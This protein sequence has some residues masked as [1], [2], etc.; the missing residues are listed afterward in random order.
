MKHLRRSPRRRGRRVAAGL[1]VS[2]LVTGLISM[3]N[4]AGAAE[5][6][7]NGEVYGGGISAGAPWVLDFPN[8]QAPFVDVAVH[9]LSGA[10]HTTL[11]VTASGD[12]VT[13]GNY[14]GIVS[15]I[16]PSL[17]NEHVIAIEAFRGRAAAVTQSGKIVTWSNA[18]TPPAAY[19][20]PT[21]PTGVVD[22][23]L[24]DDF[25]VAL[26]DD[27]T[28]DS[29]GNAG[30]VSGTPDLDNVV[31]ID[32]TRSG[33][34][35]LTADGTVHAWGAGSSPLGNGLDEVNTSKIIDIAMAN[36]TGWALTDEGEVLNFGDVDGPEA[37][38]VFPADRAEGR[39]IALQSNSGSFN[40]GG[41]A[42]T[43]NGEFVIWG[44]F[45]EANELAATPAPVELDEQQ[46]VA[47]EGAPTNHT[48]V[49]FG[50]KDDEPEPGVVSPPAVDGFPVVGSDVTGTPATFN[51]EPTSATS[52]WYRAPSPETP[53][54]DW[55]L[56][57]ET[58]PLELTSELE[59]QYVAYRTTVEGPEGATFTADSTPI[60]PIE[61]A[62]PGVVDEAKIEGIP[63]RNTQLIGIA[64]TFNFTPESVVSEWYRADS[65]DADPETWTLVS[66]A[67]PLTVATANEGKFLFFR[68]T[69]TDEGG[70]T[71]V[72][73]SAPMGPIVRFTGAPSSIQGD[74][75]VGST[76]TG[77]PGEFTYPPESMT[78]FWLVGGTQRI[79]V[80]EGGSLDLAMTEDYVGKTVQFFAQ[81]RV[82][83]LLATSFSPAI[84]PVTLPPLSAVEVPQVEGIP[85]RNTQLIGIAAVFNRPPE[86]VVSEW[87]RADSADADPETWTLVSSA[88]PL[89]VAT[90][91][92]GKFLFFRTTATDEGGQTFVS[93]SAPMGP[94]VRFTGAPSSIQGDP[95][96]GSTITGVP[97]EFTYPP[98]SMT[99]FWLVG[100]TQRIDVPEGGSLD[101]AMTEDYVGKTVQFF[102][103]GRVAGLLAT[104][105]SPAIGPVT[106][107][108]LELSGQPTVTG[109]PF[110]GET[111]TATPVEVDEGLESGLQWFAGSGDTFT[112]IEG[113]TGETFE[114]TEAQRDQQVKVVQTATRTADE[115]TDSAESVPTAA[116]TD[117]PVDLV[118]EAGA[119][120]SGTPIEG[121]TLTGTPAVYSTTEDVTVTNYWVIG[122]EEVEADGTTLVLTDEH[123]GLNIQFKSVATRGEEAVPSVSS[124]VGPVLVVLEA[125]SPPT[126]TGTPE[127]GQ[128][129]NGAPATFSDTDGVTVTNQWFADGDPIDGATTT[130]LVLT[131]DHLGAEITFVSTATRGDETPVVSESDPTAPVEEEDTTTPPGGEVVIDLDGATAPGAT[132]SVQVGT[133]LAGQQVQVYLSNLDR[134]LGPVTVAEDGTIQVLVPGDIPLGTH[135]LA[136]YAEGQLVG[137]DDFEVTL[138]RPEDPAFQDLINVS[139]DPV[140]AG[141]EV[142]IQVGAD[143][144]GQQVRVVLFSTPRDLG[145]AT[146][147]ADGTVKVTIPADMAAGV[148]RVAVYDATG[149]LIGW[150]DVTVAGDGASG[151]GSGAGNLPSTGAGDVGPMIPLGLT[152][153]LAGLGLLAYRAR[154]RHQLS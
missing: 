1:V 135:R 107:P 47:F 117:A 129:L 5:T 124:A 90:A 123:V 101:L 78:Y 95:L 147:A 154:G 22:V 6:V 125:T 25:G 97:G 79:D 98:E 44:D 75:L 20:N 74:P 108:P 31:Q 10:N 42:L 103:Q 26:K 122:D 9:A 146:V 111:L 120:L 11:A 152:L 82:A 114:L 153:L 71:F 40:T 2:A 133:G 13:Q 93:N 121:E 57:G 105:F 89:T 143:R 33:A 144:A 116:V 54:E 52:A 69:A 106:L 41:G 145:F 21:A 59:G 113:A 96:V 66:S 77:V 27:G 46:V 86:S 64:A 83:G 4:T 49:I 63:V 55:T 87:Y 53:A 16:P 14:E 3:A 28:I 29:W 61:S 73:N 65:A 126:I 109:Q 43:E 67:N 48:A 138:V 91:N 150:Q 151:S 39:I 32:A 76:I 7:A 80:P 118:V 18:A 56:I 68:T 81:G 140:K 24:G 88:N 38:N 30:I 70:Q 92:E 119:E 45:S 35:A 130:A 102:A 100:G 142:T 34:L 110:I 136:V 50:P 141:D 104:S 134:L 148:H 19:Q 36:R 84:G 8:D 51:F 137:W 99:Y 72:S 94:I 85:V 37:R 127:V 128:T 132:I 58:N 131:E 23:Q 15:L 62:P 17:T 139:P 12:I 112:A 115:A 149:A 60:G